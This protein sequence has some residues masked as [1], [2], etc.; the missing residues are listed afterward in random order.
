MIVHDT[1]DTYGNPNY[2]MA[3]SGLGVG[4]KPLGTPERFRGIPGEPGPRE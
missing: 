2:P 1:V 4:A 3:N